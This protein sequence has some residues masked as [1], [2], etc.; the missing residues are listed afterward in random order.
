MFETCCSGCALGLVDKNGEPH[1]KTWRVVTTS[2]KLAVNLGAYQCKHPKGFKH[3]PL[4][5]AET[6]RS[7]FY[8]EKMAQVISNSLYPDA[9][10]PGMPTVPFVQSEH[11]PRSVPVGVHQVIDRKIL[12]QT[13][14]SLRSHCQGK[15][16]FSCQC[17]VWLCDKIIPKAELLK[18]GNQ[19]NLG[20]LMT[21]LSVKHAESPTLRKLKARVV[22]RGDQIV[23]ESN[24]IAIL[25]EL[26]VNPSGIT[27]INFNLS[28]GALKGNKSTQ[29]DVVRAYTQSLLRTKVPTW[30]LLPPELVP[31]EY[32]HIKDPVAPLDKALYG[33][34]DRFREVMQLMGGS[35]DQDNQSNWTFGNVL[36][37]T[38]SCRI[39]ENFVQSFGNRTT[40]RSRPMPGKKACFHHSED[41]AEVEFDMVDFIQSSCDFYVELAGHTFLKEVCL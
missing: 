26:K 34:P 17:E 20:R 9:S 29:S 41:S 23:D 37:L 15:G 21:I 6:S 8:T 35:P 11:V 7:A 13:S 16:W 38:S 4:K 33:H 25:Q 22:F 32:S 12:E 36:L 28:Y 14:G 3:S 24:N 10:V 2:M 5:G 40:N 27:A 30:V 19:Y 39:L 31:K 1:K 18:S